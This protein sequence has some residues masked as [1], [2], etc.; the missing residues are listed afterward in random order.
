[1]QN[2]VVIPLLQ[3]LATGALSALAAGCLARFFGGDPWTWAAGV[4]SLAGLAAWLI[5]TTRARRADELAQGVDLEPAQPEQPKAKESVTAWIV[6][7]EQSAGDLVDLPC[8]RAQI[9]ALAVGVMAGQG[10]T[11][12]TWCGSD[13]PFSRHEW[14]ALRAVF[15]ARGLA[16]W[17]HPD[18]VNLGW[19][20]TGKG[21]ALMRFYSTTTPPGQPGKYLPTSPQG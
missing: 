3:A 5:L 9:K 11:T 2:L 17:N 18:R 1:M 10:L 13:A 21:R 14:E 12:A 7:S 8:T 4:G 16:K 19:T 15:I 20:L 6:N